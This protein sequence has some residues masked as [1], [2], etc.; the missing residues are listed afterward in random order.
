MTETPIAPTRGTKP[1]ETPAP[2]AAAKQ[3]TE[4]LTSLGTDITALLAAIK[5]RPEDFRAFVTKS[6]GGAS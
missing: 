3:L 6:A 1:G 2:D 4:I 5:E